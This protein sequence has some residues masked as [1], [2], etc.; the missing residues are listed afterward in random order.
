MVVALL[1]TVKGGF[2]DD[3]S[4]RYRAGFVIN[5]AY[6]SIVVSP[7][8]EP[9]FRASLMEQLATIM[10]IHLQRIVSLQ[11]TDTAEGTIAVKL[12]VAD[13]QTEMG[14]PMEAFGI[15]GTKISSNKLYIYWSGALMETVSSSFY[16]QSSGDLIA[17]S[18]SFNILEA[19]T[20]LITDYTA[21]ILFI[22]SMK[23]QMA[24]LMG[25]QADR[26][27]SLNIVAGVS[28]TNAISKVTFDIIDS[29][30]EDIPAQTALQ[31]LYA[32][33]T[34]GT[35]S[36]SAPDGHILV[37]DMTS[38]EITSDVGVVSASYFTLCVLLIFTIYF[39]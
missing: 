25:I 37:L 12:E 20:S 8:V 24:T 31:T 26:I 14:S 38:I 35:A 30:D 34:S 28:G 18:I 27:E 2:A 1:C 5:Q 13:E 15:L 22:A 3:V 23:V 39:M 32:K 16:T 29:G 9:V 7:A 19:Y 17:Y 10:G 6:L 4:I 33:L 21:K 11:V 36:L